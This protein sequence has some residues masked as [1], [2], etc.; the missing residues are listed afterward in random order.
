MPKVNRH[1]QLGIPRQFKIHGHSI[2]VLIISIEN[3][4]YGDTVGLYDPSDHTISLRSDQS[5][6]ALQQTFCHELVHA[7]LHEMNHKLTHDEV[8]V[9]NFGSLLHQAMSTFTSTARKLKAV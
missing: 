8:F 6:T 3:W 7:V 5:D 4:I 2:K 1:T 9:D